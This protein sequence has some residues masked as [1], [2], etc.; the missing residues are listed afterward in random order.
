MRKKA[1]RT[2]SPGLQTQVGLI[3]HIP[4]ILKH[5]Q[6]MSASRSYVVL[7]ETISF[8]RHGKGP[9]N[10]EVTGDSVKF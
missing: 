6:I 3:L 10:L 4:F 1:R 8:K 5:V 7:C 2:V 9:Q